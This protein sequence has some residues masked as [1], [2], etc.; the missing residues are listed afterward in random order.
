MKRR[1]VMKNLALGTAAGVSGILRD[2][3]EAVAQTYS[4]AT[5]GLPPLKITRVKSI[6][7]APHNAIMPYVIVKVETSEP[8]LY[9]IGCASYFFR[10]LA[11]V[12]L[13][14]KYM[15]PLFRG[16][17][18]NNIEDIWQDML[19][20]TNTR[21]GPALN[22]AMSGMDMALWDIKGKR[23]NM[24]VYELFG[25]KSRFA[26]DCYAHASGRDFAELEDRVK[27][28]MEEGYRHIRIELH[29]EAYGGA[30]DQEPDFKKAGF[31]GPDDFCPDPAGYAVTIPKM[32][33]YIRNKCGDK[34]ELLHDMIYT[35]IQP[36][37][38]INMIKKL[39]PY[40]PFFIEDPF[41]VEDKDYLKLLRQQ[42]GVP[43][44][45]GEKF[46]N[47][48]TYVDLISGRLIDFI[49]CHIPYI[50]GLTPARK[51]A[52]MGELH[53]VRTAWHGPADNS[54][55]GHAAHA[56]LDLN[57]WNFGIQERVIFRQEAID[58][59]P[60]TPTIKNGYMYVN[61]APG[62]GIDINEKLA[63]KFPLAEDHFSWQER[64]KRYNDGT[65]RR[66]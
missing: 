34:I 21:Y 24:P 20:G 63:A 45:L 11:V 61:E 53:N 66:S 4:K 65:I 16:K 29:R 58:V 10:P 50:G 35:R 31:G 19:A 38:A 49:R 64:N 59:F 26:V 1:D 57:I 14:D 37:D 9:G 5:R 62:L 55:V 48:N 42:T 8:G 33:E 12:T 44:A 27:R 32:F 39:E 17:N 40:R 25:G 43:I 2:K 60:G 15:D 6:L 54:P 36:I 47:P 7:T 23:A 13:I 46:I 51:I 30:Q 41:T 18:S 56:H 3:N 52:A 22:S 28:Y